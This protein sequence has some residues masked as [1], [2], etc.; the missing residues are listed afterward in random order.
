VDDAPKTVRVF[1]NVKTTN[2]KGKVVRS[3]LNT[4]DAMKDPEYREQILEQAKR[5]L[6]QFITKYES[7]SELADVLNPIKDYLRPG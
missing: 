5:E 4:I 7:L 2:E 3:Y 1:T 6:N